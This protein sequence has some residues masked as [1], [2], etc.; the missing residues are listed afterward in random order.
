MLGIHAF[1]IGLLST[2]KPIRT[3]VKSMGV[4][5]REFLQW[6]FR[7]TIRHLE[8]VSDA[9]RAAILEQKDYAIEYQF[10]KTSTII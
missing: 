3:K 6:T 7:I 10:T 2:F 1:E 8:F 9:Q 5:I 4:K